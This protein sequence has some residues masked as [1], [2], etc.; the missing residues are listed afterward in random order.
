MDG[1]VHLRL[2]FFSIRLV[3]DS[4]I[5]CY[6][7]QLFPLKIFEISESWEL[8]LLKTRGE[9]VGKLVFTFSYY[10]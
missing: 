5:G 8:R 3:V 9:V 7:Y 4:K 10:I 2:K 1:F 6:S